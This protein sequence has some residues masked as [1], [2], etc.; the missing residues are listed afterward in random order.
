[1]PWRGEKVGAGGQGLESPAWRGDTPN[2][3]KFPHPCRPRDKS[4][5][6][7]DRSCSLRDKSCLSR[8]NPALSGTSPA[9]PG[10]SPALPGRSPGLSGRPI[11]RRTK[12]PQCPLPQLP[13]GRSPFRRRGGSEGPD[14]TGSS[15]AEHPGPAVSR[16][17]A[18]GSGRGLGCSSLPV[19]SLIARLFR[20]ISPRCLSAAG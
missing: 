13:R 8:V 17:T 14:P 9:L 19:A 6:P 18:G 15:R 5:P 16:D 12:A 4:C 1:M 7:R 10:T 11:R 2:S 3:P 20:A